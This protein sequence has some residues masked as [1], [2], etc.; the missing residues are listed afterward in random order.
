MAL[1]G[2][3][4]LLV[5][6]GFNHQPEAVASS[7]VEDDLRVVFLDMPPVPELEEPEKV[8]DADAPAEELD[9][10]AYVPMQADIPTF[11]AD[12]VFTQQMDYQSLLPKPDFDAA[13]VVT[14]PTN[15]G[16]G[17]IDPSKIKDVFNLADLDRIPEPI[18]QP[19][20]VFPAQLKNDVSEARVVVEFIVDP[21]GKVV[22]AKM[23]E[24]T[25]HGFED[26][27]ILGVSRWQFRA[28]MK[29]GKRVSTRMRVPLMFRVVEDR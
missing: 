4:H 25:H 12:A 23:I 22:W 2:G 13:K 26:A 9:P 17:R 16:R 27:A 11:S 19:P 14:I 20:P 1:A 29:N 7:S 15:V 21:D 28:G 8:F 18:F 24:T 3:V 5:L 6:Y 10:G